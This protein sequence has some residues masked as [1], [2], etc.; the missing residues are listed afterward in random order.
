MSTDGKTQ[1]PPILGNLSKFYGAIVG[2]I[3]AQLLLRWLGIDVQALGVAYEF[4]AI[5][6]HL[7]DVGIM[8]GGSLVAGAVTYLFPKNYEPPERDDEA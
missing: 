5:V 2:A 3:L 7:I 8:V 4:N 6:I 1:K